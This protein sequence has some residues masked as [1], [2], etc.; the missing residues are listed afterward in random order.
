MARIYKYTIDTKTGEATLPVDAKVLE[1]AEEDPGGE[2]CI[3]AEVDPDQTLTFTKAVIIL[4]TGQEVPS[5][6]QHHK[7]YQQG[8]LVLHLYVEET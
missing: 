2:P 8:P 1:V 7:T 4:M 5:G 3:W 6:F